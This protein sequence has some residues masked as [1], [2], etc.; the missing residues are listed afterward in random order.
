MESFEL[1]PNLSFLNIIF[2]KVIFRWTTA[3]TVIPTYGPTPTPLP[4]SQPSSTPS[5]QPTDDPSSQPIQAPTSAPSFK[6]EFWGEVTNDWHQ[7]HENRWTVRQSLLPPRHLR[8]EL[9][10][11]L[12]HRPRWW[13]GVDRTR[14]LTSNLSQGLRLGRSRCWCQR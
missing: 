3:P 12:L 9:Q 7:T 11:Q 1:E 5:N 6:A 2:H 4:S 13:A 10:L 8:D 14:L